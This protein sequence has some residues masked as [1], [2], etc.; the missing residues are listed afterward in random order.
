MEK[1]EVLIKKYKLPPQ[2]VWAEWDEKQK[3]KFLKLQNYVGGKQDYPICAVDVETTGLD[4]SKHA[5]IQ[6]A[7]VPLDRD[8]HPMDVEPFY[9]LIAPEGNFEVAKEAMKVNGLDMEEVMLK[10]HSPTKVAELLEEWVKK[11]K[12]KKL[13]PLGQQYSF[14]EGFIKEWL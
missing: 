14:D 2:G 3:R 7:I 13:T 8:F 6:I 12:A 4:P 10:G 11:L 9:H 5:L 1:Y